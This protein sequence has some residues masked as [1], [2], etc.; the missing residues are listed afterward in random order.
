MTTLTVCGSSGSFPGPSRACSSYLVRGDGRQL[1]LDLGSGALTNLLRWTAA[2]ELTDVFISHGHH[3]HFADLIGL[4]QLASYGERRPRAVRVYGNR[5]TCEVVARMVDEHAPRAD[6]LE[7]IEV[8]VDDRFQVDN[9]TIQTYAVWHSQEGLLARITSPDGAT[10]AYT[11]DSDLCESLVEGARD[12]DLLVSEATWLDTGREYPQGVH[13]TGTQAG[14]LARLAGANR[15]L[16]THVW[17]EF[18]PH[19][20]AAQA[21]VEHEGQTLVAED[22]LTITLGGQRR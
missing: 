18:D 2:E 1:V 10:I 9:F 7:L 16:V 19:D 8:A 22:N 6:G 21:A 5:A 4:L 17:P 15:L 12:V 11:G 3:D 13:M 14:R 20:V